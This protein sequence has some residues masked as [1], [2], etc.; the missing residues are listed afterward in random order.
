MEQETPQEKIDNLENQVGTLKVE[1]EMLQEKIDEAR[2][3]LDIIAM[4]LGTIS[5]NLK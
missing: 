1:N 3:L 4:D 2:K 5:E